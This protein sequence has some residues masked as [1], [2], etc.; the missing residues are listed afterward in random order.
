MYMPTVVAP[1]GED[2]ERVQRALE[3][4]RRRGLEALRE[5]QA[6]WTN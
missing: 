4:A 3:E 6:K 2:G 5:L 1:T